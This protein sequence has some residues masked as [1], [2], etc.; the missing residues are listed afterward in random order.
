V[1]KALQ[2]AKARFKAAREWI[3]DRVFPRTFCHILVWIA[4]GVVLAVAP[5]GISS[6]LHHKPAGLLDVVPAPELILISI[7]L[8]A[9]AFGDLVLRT[10]LS[11]ELTLKIGTKAAYPLGLIVMCFGTY[12]YANISESGQEKTP[13]TLWWSFGIVV[14]SLLVAGFTITVN[15]RG[16]LYVRTRE[17]DTVAAAIEAWAAAN[18]QLVALG[19]SP[20]VRREVE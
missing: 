4:F 9:G 14:A 6:I 19:K 10:I 16:E 20:V 2:T 13:T 3:Q 11:A 18:G 12:M 7:A 17:K 5:F 15:E 1:I 8:S